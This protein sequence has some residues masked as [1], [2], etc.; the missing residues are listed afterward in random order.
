MPRVHHQIEKQR[1]PKAFGSI[2]KTG[3]LSGRNGGF[4]PGN[5]G[6]VGDSR[7]V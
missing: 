3:N 7:C 4:D 6:V 1:N 5:D 2:Q